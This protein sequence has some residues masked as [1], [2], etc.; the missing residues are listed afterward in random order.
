[1]RLEDSFLGRC[2]SSFMDL[3]GLDRA[4]GIA[5]QSFTALIPLL[6]LVSAVLPTGDGNA[7][8]ESIVRRFHLTGDAARSV[9]MVFA[10]SEPASV[11]LGSLLLLVF[12]GVSLTR[13]LQR[14]Y[15]QAYGLEPLSGVRGSF[16]AALGLAVLLVEI[17]LLYFLRTLVRALPFDWALGLPLSVLASLALWTSVPFLLLDRRVP[18]QRLFPAG[19]LAGTAVSLYGVATTFYMPRLM[20]SY[21][22]RYGLF[23]VTVAIV[24]WLLCVAI[25]LV[26]TTV[27]AAELDRAPDDWA[28]RLRARLGAD[29]P[30]PARVPRTDEATGPSR[31]E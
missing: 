17:A 31:D 4:M 26:A 12:S 11:G 16:N 24:G 30:R 15:L 1:M 10:Q 22:E 27:I 19:A 28:R 5:S 21:S 18:W 23:G 20:T 6:I 2:V 25:I 9:E 8:A 14:L 3:Q 29:L 7:V 13:R